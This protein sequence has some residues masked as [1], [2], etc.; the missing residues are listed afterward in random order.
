VFVRVDR[1]CD[2]LLQY[3][4]RKLFKAKKGY[5]GSAAP[6]AGQGLTLVHISAQPEPLLF[7]GATASVHFSAQ[8]ET[9]LPAQPLHISHQTCSR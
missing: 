4:E 8:P 5:H 6:H 7:T 1:H 9:L 3:H 2:S